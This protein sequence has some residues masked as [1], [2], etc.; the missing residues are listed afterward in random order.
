MP[1]T[2]A[3]SPELTL[4]HRRAS[5][6]LNNLHMLEMAIAD[7]LTSG[8]TGNTD[9]R[10]DA[11]VDRF[12]DADLYAIDE[13]LWLRESLRRSVYLQGGPAIGAMDRSD[14]N[15]GSPGDH[16]IRGSHPIM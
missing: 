14:R 5:I 8:A 6:I 16:R 7:E 10:I 13:N 4:R 1:T 11:V 9:A 15:F 2:V 12:V 3:I